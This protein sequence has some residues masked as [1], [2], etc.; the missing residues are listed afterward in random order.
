MLSPTSKLN[1]SQWTRARLLV[2]HA[3][4]LS[5]NNQQFMRFT[6]GYDYD[7][8]EDTYTRMEYKGNK[9]PIMASKHLLVQRTKEILA[10][11]KVLFSLLALFSYS[12]FVSTGG[13]Q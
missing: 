1:A 9:V 5:Y 12:D 8:E 2:R 13:F 7:E 4:F 10:P 11:F 6:F 3:C